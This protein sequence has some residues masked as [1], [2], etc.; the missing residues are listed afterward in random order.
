MHGSTIS[1]AML[2]KRT[3][4]SIARGVTCW[5]HVTA[6]CFDNLVHLR[7]I[8]TRVAN[9]VTWN[10]TFDNKGTLLVVFVVGRVVCDW[11]SPARQLT[12]LG[13]ISHATVRMPA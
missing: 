10:A 2:Q 12:F 3:H 1:D 7:P 11:N 6:K 8:T 9:I 5:G 4:S 13:D